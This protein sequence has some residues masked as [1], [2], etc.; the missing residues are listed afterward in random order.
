[1]TRRAL[2]PFYAKRRYVLRG[3]KATPN[4]FGKFGG[5]NEPFFRSALQK[6][7]KVLDHFQF[8]HTVRS[9]FGY[10]IESKI[11]ADSHVQ[12]D[13]FADKPEPIVPHERKVM[14]RIYK[15]LVAT[16]R[17]VYTG[18]LSLLTEGYEAGLNANMC[19]ALL[20]MAGDRRDPIE[21]SF[22]WSKKITVSDELATTP[23]IKISGDH[24]EYLE[25]ASEQLYRQNPAYVS[26]EG[27]VTDLSSKGDPESE[28][29]DGRSVTIQRAYAR[30]SLA[31][32]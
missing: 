8:G 17:A 3:A 30:R 4:I 31:K 23:Q 19:T 10:R 11:I 6:A 9:S 2:R 26:I 16:D 25:A 32:G 12:Y 13:M 5:K 1:M 22:K 15:G 18:D 21:Y 14:E 28:E 7:R 29:L 27:L 20:N 24:L